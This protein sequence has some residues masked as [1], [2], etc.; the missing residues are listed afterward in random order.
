MNIDQNWAF[1][2]VGFIGR[3]NII[4]NQCTA[5]AIIENTAPIDNT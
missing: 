2:N 4:G 5:P 1:K 3:L